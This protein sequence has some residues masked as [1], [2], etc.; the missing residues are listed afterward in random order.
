MQTQG[1]KSYRVEADGGSICITGIGLSI[2][3]NNGYGDGEFD[4]HVIE[5]QNNPW[6][7]RDDWNLEGSFEVFE[8]FGEGALV[9]LE[10]SDCGGEAIHEFEPGRYGVYSSKK[11]DGTTAVVR[12]YL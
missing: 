11:R 5:D 4:C 2:S 1:V 6:F 10:S 9:S 7:I 12:W 8:V 3:Y